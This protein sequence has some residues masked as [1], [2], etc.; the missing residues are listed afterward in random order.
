MCAD[1]STSSRCTGAGRARGNSG[2][3]NGEFIV[4]PLTFRE[5]ILLTICPPNIFYNFQV[6][7]TDAAAS[8]TEGSGEAAATAEL[9][10]GTVST[11]GQPMDL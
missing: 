4:L 11:A 2:A 9:A 7:P 8:V 5:R 10:G 3:A 6:Q 1:R